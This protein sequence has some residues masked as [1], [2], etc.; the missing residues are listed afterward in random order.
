M[1][2]LLALLSSRR[3]EVA[4]R[5]LEDPVRLFDR[6]VAGGLSPLTPAPPRRTIAAGGRLRSPR[7]EI[8]LIAWPPSQA[9]PP[10]RLPLASS[11]LRRYASPARGEAAPLAA[12]SGPWGAFVTYRI[13]LIALLT[14]SFN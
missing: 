4:L 3:R 8:L 10:V 7:H 5:R 12:Q 9:A 1:T 11:P 6:E 13:I 2:R 14:K